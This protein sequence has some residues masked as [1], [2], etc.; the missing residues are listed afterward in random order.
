LFD[1]AAPAGAAAA[2]TNPTARAPV[3][4]GTASILRNLPIN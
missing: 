1:G 2:N 3:A 4:A